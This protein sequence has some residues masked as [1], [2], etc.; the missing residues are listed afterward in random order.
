[1]ITTALNNKCPDFL[2]RIWSGDIV[3]PI[4]EIKKKKKNSPI[5]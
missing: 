2:L 3:H 1:M 4:S 5:W